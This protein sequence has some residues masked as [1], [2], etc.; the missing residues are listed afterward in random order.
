MNAQ[1]KIDEHLL[2]KLSRQSGQCLDLANVLLATDEMLRVARDAN[3]ERV[4]ELEASRKK[5]LALCFAK[6]M[7]PENSQLF[8]EALAVMLHLNEELVSLLNQAKADVA[9]QDREGK[10]AQ[11]SIGQY[12][13][14]SEQTEG[15]DRGS[16]A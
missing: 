5:R 3:W 15:D 4:T 11:T 2:A 7:L 10:S 6:P 12:L 9:L 8:S 1:T 16:N 13:E 14:V